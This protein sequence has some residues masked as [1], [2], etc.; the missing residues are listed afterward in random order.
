MQRE[1]MLLMPAMK[2][3]ILS[4]GT[5]TRLRP[6]TYTSAKQLL[7][8]ANRPIVAYAIES[9]VSCGL[10]DIG[11]VVGDTADEVRTALGD[12]SQFH[13]RFTY[14]HQEKPLGLAHAVKT[15]QPFLGDAPFCMFLG[16]N[17]LR[18]GVGDLVERFRDN[19]PEAAILLAE[20]PN[21]AQFGVA[22]VE[23]GQVVRLVEKPRDPISPYALV[24]AYC[25]TSAI[26]PIINALSPSWRNEYEITDAIQGLIDNGRRVDASFVD[27]WWKD[28]GR[29]DDLLDANRLVLEELQGRIAGS[30][31]TA[32][33]VTGRVELGDGAVVKDS[34]IRGPVSIADNARISHSYIGPYTSIGPDAVLDHVEIENSVVMAEATIANLSRRIADSLIGRQ[35][36]IHG[37]DRRPSTFR[38]VLGDRSEV[39]WVP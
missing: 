15:A 26:H 2:A 10:T 16:D 1:E 23:R 36:H 19:A 13:C 12:G 28:T 14:I 37:E 25:F 33:V 17:L 4:G 35:A 22:V 32:S 7:P 9:L 3:L 27:G 29:P 30:V 39:H 31:D 18:H 24:G 38:V 21:P 6:L 11:I 34:V 5:G 8:V 20:V